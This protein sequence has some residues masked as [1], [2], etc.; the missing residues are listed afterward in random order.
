MIPII[1]RR[2][3]FQSRNEIWAAKGHLAAGLK[4]GPSQSHV[5]AHLVARAARPVDD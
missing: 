4:I 5:G 2:I 1:H 3:G